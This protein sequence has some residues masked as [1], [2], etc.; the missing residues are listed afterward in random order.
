MFVIRTEYLRTNENAR[1]MN[2]VASEARIA[3]CAPLARIIRP[4]LKRDKSDKSRVSGNLY[5]SPLPMII[6]DYR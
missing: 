5:G 6:G 4:F 2:E 3:R 1:A